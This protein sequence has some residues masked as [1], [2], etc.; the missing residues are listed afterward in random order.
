MAEISANPLRGLRLLAT[1]PAHQS[2]ELLAQLRALGASADNFPTIEIINPLSDNTR[3]KRV[4]E[5]DLV[6]FISGN[7]VTYGLAA[8]ERV[9]VAHTCLPQ[10]VAVGRGTAALLKTAGVTDV[11]HPA[12]PSSQ[13]L[14][15]MP[16]VKALPP[17]SKVLVF[18]GH[19]GKEVLAAG[20]RAA[21]MVVDYAEVY[22]R[23]RPVGV[24]L[25]FTG[26]KPDLILIT[27]RDGLHNLYTMTDPA[28]RD[29]LLKTPIVLGSESILDLHRE[30]GFQQAPI[31]AAS[32]LDDDMVA[33]IVA[34]HR[35]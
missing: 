14:L 12:Q 18:R 31:I 21:G 7:A 23:R 15:E 8:L 25:S 35:R 16:T 1:R 2:T 30:L 13:S 3:L 9:G 34:W 24:E 11:T 19:G 4:S 33:A 26:P 17:A 28:S 10:T 5:Y 32:P 27:S 20:L 6:I 22:A 29:Q